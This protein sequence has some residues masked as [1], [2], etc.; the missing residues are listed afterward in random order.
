VSQLK[1]YT[2]EL[3]HPAQA[4]RAMMDYKGLQYQNVEMLAG[5]HDLR[6]RAAGF[7]AGTVPALKL[8]DGRRV[9]GSLEISRALDELAPDP[10]LF[11]ADPERRQAVEEAERWGEEALQPVARRI[12]RAAL[13]R[14]PALRRWF[15]EASGLP[16]AVVSG[17]AI[18]PVARRLARSVGAT[19]EQG[20]RD[21]AAL[22][23]LLD[24]VD[25]LL[26]E[27]VIGGEQP[28]AA[29]FQ[30]GASVR[31]TMAWD[32]LR[33]LVEGRPAAVHALALFPGYAGPIPATMPEEWLAPA[34]AASRG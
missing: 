9:Q 18:V 1:L 31:Y 6:L 32:D 25:A 12:G 27:G 30:I 21:V 26:A 7:A 17:P 10:P 16:V 11:P 8:T 14:D 20:A 29:D 28:N 2:L 15:A 19:Q 34:R 22:P 24:R 4:A 33:P 3:S 23:G 13:V 5:L